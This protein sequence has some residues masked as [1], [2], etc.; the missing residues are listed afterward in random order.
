[1]SEQ[2]LQKLIHDLDKAAHGVSVA[3]QAI[4]REMAERIAVLSRART[5][6]FR[7]LNFMKAIVAAI[8]AAEDYASAMTHATT[9]FLR[10]TNWNGASETQRE[11][12]E[13]FLPVANAIWDLQQS[14][15]KDEAE[16]GEQVGDP[17]VVERHLADFE[18][19][20]ELN[21]NAPFLS[22]MDREVLELPL[23]EVA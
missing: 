16:D 8:A 7:R 20:F 23:V 10:E 22:L 21:R 19:W 9:A 6:A 12:V 11:V 14:G 1:M 18:Q 17:A 2:G 13:K 3:E 15:R 4:R 5:F